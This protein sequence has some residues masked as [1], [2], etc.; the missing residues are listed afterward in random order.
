MGPMG[1]SGPSGKHLRQM[2]EILASPETGF[3][4]DYVAEEAELIF[5]V[6]VGDYEHRGQLESSM[7]YHNLFSHS[8]PSFRDDINIIQTAR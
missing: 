4:S 7:H 2:V 1:V 8:I 3:L 5:F 6:F